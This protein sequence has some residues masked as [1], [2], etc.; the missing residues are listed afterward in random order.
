M[1]GRDQECQPLLKLVRSQILHNRIGASEVKVARYY[2]GLAI[3]R[4]G[5]VLTA[6]GWFDSSLEIPSLCR[7]D[8]LI[9]IA[10]L[11]T[12][13]DLFLAYSDIEFAERM[14]KEA[15]SK[16]Q[17]LGDAGASSIAECLLRLAKV[18]LLHGD[19]DERAISMLEEALT[20]LSKQHLKSTLLHVH[21]LCLLAVTYTDRN[22]SWARE[23]AEEALRLSHSQ[24]IECEHVRLSA[25]V[26]LACIKAYDGE[27]DKALSELSGAI[28]EAEKTLGANHP[29]ILACQAVRIVVKRG[30]GDINSADDSEIRRISNSLPKLHALQQFLD[31]LQRLEPGTVPALQKTCAASILPL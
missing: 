4:S 30:F 3:A 2:L 18:I 8:E 10:T 26:T 17:R 9:D 5:D 1:L 27:R 29:S 22:A 28:A 16:A 23:F 7:D 15:M 12:S 11:L 6:S 19:D 21:T 24:P 20:L 31:M 25:K 14:A 13:S